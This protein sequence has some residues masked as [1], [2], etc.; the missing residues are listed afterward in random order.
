MED[1]HAYGTHPEGVPSHRQKTLQIPSYIFTRS[2][3]SGEELRVLG[4]EQGKSN[5]EENTQFRECLSNAVSAAY[6]TDEP[7]HNFKIKT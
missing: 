3:V 2:L 5:T 4:S 7:G 6:M 1:T